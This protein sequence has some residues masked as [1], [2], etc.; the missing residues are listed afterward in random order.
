MGLSAGLR[1]RMLNSALT[2]QKQMLREK[3]KQQEAL[4]TEVEDVKKALENNDDAFSAFNENNQESS[5]TISTKD[6]PNEIIL[7]NSGVTINKPEAEK[8]DTNKTN[9]TQANEV[10]VSK[11]SQEQKELN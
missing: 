8:I 2:Q 10:S 1:N 7:A 5:A 3:I 6:I 11:E 9:D 4:K